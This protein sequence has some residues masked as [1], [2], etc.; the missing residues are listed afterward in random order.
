MKPDI[1]VITV[2]Y[3]GL[4]LTAAMIASLRQYVST[5]IE[6]IVVDNGSHLLAERFPGIVAIRSERNLGFAGGNNLGLRAARGRYLLLLNNDTEVGDDSLHYLCDA[7]ENRPHWGAVSPKI[8]FADPPRPIQF[9]GYTPLSKITLRNGL[10]GF[11]RED[12][13]SY[14]T[15][16]E[17]PYAH[18]AAMMVR[19]ETIEQAGEMPELYFLY[20]EELDWSERITRSGWDIGYEPR[21]TVFHKESRTTGRESP[22]RTY[23]LTR[24]RLL[25]GWRNR[26]G[27]A[28]LLTVLY[29]CGVAA[30]KNAATALLRGRGDLARATVRG[31]GAFFTMKNKTGEMRPSGAASQYPVR[32]VDR[33]RH[34]PRKPHRATGMFYAA[35]AIF[36]L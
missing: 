15:P 13:G 23:Y 28:R 8:R 34:T 11:N 6:I 3:N 35:C 5:P 9:A 1:S 22:L 10:V 21:C 2:N 16:H 19:R 30:P 14:D 31:V 27:A 7:L 4:E 17:T 29:Q 24:N 36:G 32:W 20:Y 25:F 26:H 12:D 18:G 33:Q